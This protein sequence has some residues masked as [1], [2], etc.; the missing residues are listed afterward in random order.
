[1]EGEPARLRGKCFGCGRVWEEER[2]LAGWLLCVCG[3]PL[4]RSRQF[5]ED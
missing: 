5:V 2:W 4:I 1:M 3:K